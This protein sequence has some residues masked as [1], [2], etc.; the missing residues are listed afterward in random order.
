MMDHETTSAGTTGPKFRLGQE[1]EFKFK[2]RGLFRFPKTL[3]GRIEIIDD[4][5]GESRCFKG[6]D[7]SY[8]VMVERSPL[9]I[10]NGRP[11]PCL[12]KHI[13]ECDLLA[14]EAGMKRD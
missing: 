5:R 11:G 9:G 1:V 3:R 8:D 2:P 4:R 6:C 12:H 7:W 14:V 13:P 10:E